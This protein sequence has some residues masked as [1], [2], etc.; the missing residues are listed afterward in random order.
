MKEIT[1][2][3]QNLSTD[4]TTNTVNIRA[5]LNNTSD[6]TIKYATAAGCNICVITCEGMVDTQA[7]ANLIYRPLTSLEHSELK[8]DVLMEKLQSHLLISVSQEHIETYEDLSES[9]MSGFAIILADGV[10]YGVAVAVQGFNTRSVDR[11]LIHS[12]MRGSNEG[13]AESLR[14]NVSL[15]RRR[16]KSPTFVVKHKTVGERSQTAVSL[17]YLSDKIDTDML[18]QVEERLDKATQETIKFVK[19]ANGKNG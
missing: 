19:E 13:F 1:N 11:P 9:F 18:A 2:L 5:I 16:I 8:P 7:I 4:L 15:V 14:T 10:D 17:C 12:N 3:T 6:L